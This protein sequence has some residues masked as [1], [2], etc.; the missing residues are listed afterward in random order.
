[1]AAF[2]HCCKERSFVVDFEGE[3]TVLVRCTEIR[4]VNC[5]IGGRRRGLEGETVE[6]TE[7]AEFELDSVGCWVGVW[8]PVCTI[9]DGEFDAEGLW[10]G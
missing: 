1:M 10:R 3:D 6:G 7:H 2:L 5:G 9:P 8:S 4:A